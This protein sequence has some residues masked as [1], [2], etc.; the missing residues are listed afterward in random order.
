M[1]TIVDTV[2]PAFDY[3]TYTQV[4]IPACPVCQTANPSVPAVDRYGYLVGTS[5]CACGFAYLNPQL[6]A[7][8]YAAFYNQAYRPL[9]KAA[10]KVT[11]LPEGGQ[12]R[13]EWLGL[14]LARL[15]PRR[16]LSAACDVGG[17]HGAVTEGFCRVWPVERMTV[18]DPNAAELAKAEARGFQTINAQIETFPE[19][20]PQDVLL[21]NQTFDHLR[22]PMGALRW[23]HRVCVKDGWLYLD[24]V[25]APK[26][27]E[28]R[29]IAHYDW[30]LDHPGYWTPAS[31]HRALTVT[32]WRLRSCGHYGNPWPYHYGVW[33]QKKEN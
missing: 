13:G 32:G 15:T 22:D 8:G 17:S 24:I 28:V 11:K 3:T 18:I 16:P 12:V 21:C 2:A 1:P 4:P 20:P 27:A 6:S 5:I 7:E 31:L 25:D 33:C 30:K 10:S 23:L 19:L 9:V 29:Q 26:W 14:N